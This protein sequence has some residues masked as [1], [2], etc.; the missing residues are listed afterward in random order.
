MAVL[1]IYCIDKNGGKI[2]STV[3]NTSCYNR[4]IPIPNL[5]NSTQHNIGL[6]LEHAD[7]IIWVFLDCSDFP[8]SS[9]D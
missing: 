7:S 6:G 8:C 5:G 1:L 3:D 4:Y 9:R 2:C